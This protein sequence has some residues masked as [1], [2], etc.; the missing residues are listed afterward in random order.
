MEILTVS[1]VTSVIKTTL[2]EVPALR[3]FWLEGEVS[4]FTRA[5]SGHC[6]FTLKDA[7]ARIKCVMWRSR[8]ASLPALPRDGQSVFAHGHVSVYPAQGIYQFY[9]DVLHTAGEG[10]L[11]LQFEELKRKLAEEGLFAAERK[12]PLPPFPQ[13][14]GVITSSVGAALQDIL[15]VLR[16]RYPL[17]EVVLAPTAVQGAEA[18]AQIAEA[19]EKLNRLGTVEVIIVARGGGSLEDLWPFNEEI[20]G[21]AIAGSSVPVISGVGHEVDF[22]IAD[23]A[24]DLRAPTPSAAAELV[25][26]SVDDLRATVAAYRH[27][28]RQL[29]QQRLAEA[30]RLLDYQ[31]QAIARVSP[32]VQIDQFKQQVDDTMRRATTQIHHILQA[33]SLRLNGLRLQLEGL[34]PIRTLERGYAI[35]THRETNQLIRHV[36]DAVPGDPL[37]VRVS[38]G[39]FPVTREPEESRGET[40]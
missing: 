8:A 3:D 14:I 33:H 39:S 5:T 21:R 37:R 1:E 25:A 27:Q 22:T 32:R 24:A 34:S 36:G 15:K 17:A 11:F 2:D 12:R 7:G 20:V 40:F 31:R 6:Y 19:V 35:V 13:R 29:L 26:P 4:N 10:N 18:A 38:D 28:T 30:R 23:L 9:A 16:R